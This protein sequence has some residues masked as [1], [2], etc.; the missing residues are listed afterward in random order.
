MCERER[1]RDVDTHAK[2]NKGIKVLEA[3]K[4]DNKSCGDTFHAASANF[5][6]ISK[7]INILEEAAEEQN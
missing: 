3:A 7:L 5:C 1:E 4:D 2:A 6:L